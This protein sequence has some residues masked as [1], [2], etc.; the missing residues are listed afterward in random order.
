LRPAPVQVSY[1][2][3]PGTTGADFIDYIITDK[4]VT[5]EDQSLYYTE[6]FVYMPHCYQINDNMQPVSKR[7]WKRADFGLPENSFIFCSFNNSYKIDPILF[8]SWMRIL[9]Q[10]PD[11]VLWLGC[12]RKMVEDNLKRAAEERGIEF[13]RLIFA[14]TMQKDEHLSRLKFADLALDTRIVNGH[15]TT[16]DTLWAGVPVV[17]LQGGHFASR[18]SSSI[19]SA[20]GLPELITY[21]LDEYEALATRL[22]LSPPE[23]LHIRQRIAE[24]RLAM[25]LFDTPRFVRNLETAYKEM[26][27]IFL[28]GEKPRQIE[29]KDKAR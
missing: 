5:P 6:K 14:E 29:V 26:R 4:I 23:L 28:A 7:E 16:S 11:S 17:T 27:K 24:N 18:V 13:E 19:L 15:T 20:I 2:G 1:L 12:G 8:D 21:N 9:K 25:P 10:V 22:A 3:F